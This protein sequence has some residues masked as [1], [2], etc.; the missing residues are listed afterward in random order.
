MSPAARLFQRGVQLHPLGS[1]GL[2]QLCKLPSGVAGC[3]HFCA[4][5]VPISRV[6]VVA[7]LVT[8]MQCFL[9]LNP[10]NTLDYGRGRSFIACCLMLML[11]KLSSIFQLKS[12]QYFQMCFP[13]RSFPNPCF[14][15][16]SLS[17]SSMQY[18]LSGSQPVFI[19]CF[20][21]IKSPPI[22]SSSL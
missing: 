12:C 1:P 14:A 17:P 22:F 4:F 5:Q 11:I 6:V 16:D 13:C 18:Y 15:D 7:F 9:V 2:I 8:F 20:L 3:K 10:V 21:C 19:Q